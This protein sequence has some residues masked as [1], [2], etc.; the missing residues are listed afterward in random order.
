MAKP[1]VTG[2]QGLMNPALPVVIAISGTDSAAFNTGGMALCGIIL[3]AAFT[4]TSISFLVSDAIDGTFV[5]LKSTTSGT[6]LSYTVA[7]GNYCAV[8]P[9]DFQ[10]VHFLKIKS[11]SSEAAARTL[12]CSLKG[13]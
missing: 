8:D 10:G 2:Y 1:I 9:K 6:L 7:Q 11:G 3:P 4:G 12:L 5:P 13:F